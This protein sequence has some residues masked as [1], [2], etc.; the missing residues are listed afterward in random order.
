MNVRT[1]LLTSQ[2]LAQVV[3]VR[4]QGWPGLTF[5]QNLPEVLMVSSF[6]DFPLKGRHIFDHWLAMV[7]VCLDN[8]D[9]VKVNADWSVVYTGEGR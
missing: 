1:D 7:G 6:K 5:T 8:N 4:E 9:G 2:V 3:E